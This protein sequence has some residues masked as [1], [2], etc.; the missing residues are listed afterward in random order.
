MIICI[1]FKKLIFTLFKID[2]WNNFGVAIIL[3]LFLD[4]SDSIGIVKEPWL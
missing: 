2:Y 1:I 3:E 4:F